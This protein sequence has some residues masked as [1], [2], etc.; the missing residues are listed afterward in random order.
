MYHFANQ[1]VTL[2]SHL[3]KKEKLLANEYANIVDLYQ[4]DYI[5]DLKF[6]TLVACQGGLDKQCRPRRSNLTRIFPVCY[7]D[8]HFVNAS[9]DNQH[10]ILEQI[11]KSV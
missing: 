1:K 5:N 9:H 8:I 3:K 4:T 10:F 6:Q 7:S 2:F 11:E